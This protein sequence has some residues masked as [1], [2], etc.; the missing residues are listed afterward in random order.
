[1]LDMDP[2]NEDPNTIFS[3]VKMKLGSFCPNPAGGHQ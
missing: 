1:M 2:Q 3:C